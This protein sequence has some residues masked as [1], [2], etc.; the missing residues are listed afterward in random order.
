ML[1]LICGG[2][3]VRYYVAFVCDNRLSIAA[4]NEV[5]KCFV[6]TALYV[7]F[8]VNDVK[9]TGKAICARFDVFDRRRN[10]VD[11]DFFDVVGNE[12]EAVVSDCKGIAFDFRHDCVGRTQDDCARNVLFAFKPQKLHNC[13]L[14]AAAVG[15]RYDADIFVFIE[16]ACLIACTQA[17][18][19]SC[20]HK[21]ARYYQYD[22]HFLF[23][24]LSPFY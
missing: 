5:E 19:K 7:F 1:N 3:V 24:K 4:F 11:F 15:T 21:Q 22:F 13:R 23:H 6:K 12:S 8:F 17:R 20:R 9:R 10:A 18:Q 14:C 2:V 16:F